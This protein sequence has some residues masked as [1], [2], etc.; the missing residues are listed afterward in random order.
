MPNTADPGFVLA[1]EMAALVREAVESGGYATAT[2]VITEALRE[3]RLRHALSPQEQDTMRRLWAEGRAS[4]PGRLGSIE[5]IKREAR[6]QSRA[7]GAGS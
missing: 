2:E 3:W 7:T 1:P 5:A 4:G 6:R